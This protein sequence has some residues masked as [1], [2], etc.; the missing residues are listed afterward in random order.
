MKPAYSLFDMDMS[1]YMD[2]S[3]Y[4]AAFK[5]PAVDVDAL[6]ASCRR[7]I[8]AVTAANQ[9]AL[10]GVGALMRRQ[11]EIARDSAESY[12]KAVGDLMAEGSIDEKAA[13]QAQLARDGYDR[14]I[15]NARELG[16]MVT[17]TSN[18]AF[19]VL[20]DRIREGLGEVQD[21][22]ASGAVRMASAVD[23]TTAASREAVSDSMKVT[24]QVVG[25]VVAAAD[26]AMKPVAPKK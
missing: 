13:R 7:N 17:K 24:D 23:Q 3:K 10:E 22:V 16:D 5:V 6:M 9:C 12:T 21:I 11:A 25:Q 19:G 1:K 15:K 26:R 18:E 4:M 2:V 8:E 14:A 20:N